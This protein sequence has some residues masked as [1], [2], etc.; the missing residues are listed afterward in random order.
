[1]SMSV[2]EK[3]TTLI[4]FYL[5][6]VHHFIDGTGI[7]SSTTAT[8]ATTAQLLVLLILVQLFNCVVER[9]WC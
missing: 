2:C 4:F 3:T 1:M 6:L 7:G 8:N 9:N 5:E